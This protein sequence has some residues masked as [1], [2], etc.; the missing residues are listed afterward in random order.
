MRTFQFHEETIC[1]VIP[2][3]R[4]EGKARLKNPVM[5]YNIVQARGDVGR[6]F[7]ISLSNSHESGKL[8]DTG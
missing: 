8:Q 6:D 4:M 3:D 5:T 7:E 2:W 1:F